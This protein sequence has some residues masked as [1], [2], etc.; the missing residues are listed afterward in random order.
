MIKKKLLF[1]IIKLKKNLVFNSFWLSKIINIL[2][3]HILTQK[4][5]NKIYKTFSVFKIKKKLP[6]LFFTYN[7]IRNQKL[8]F[9]ILKIRVAGRI[10][11]LPNNFDFFNRYNVALKILL[12]NIYIKGISSFSERVSRYLLLETFIKN[13]VTDKLRNEIYKTVGSFRGYLHFRWRN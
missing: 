12:K 5:E 9:R 2:T 13:N 11:Q 10:Y 4:I 3:K 7:T 8:L 1:T 6:A